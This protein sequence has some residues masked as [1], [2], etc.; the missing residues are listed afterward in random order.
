MESSKRTTHITYLGVLLICCIINTFR[1][2]LSVSVFFI[3]DLLLLIYLIYKFKDV[4]QAVSPLFFIGAILFFGYLIFSPE[5]PQIEYR[6]NF[7]VPLKAF[8]YICILS[9]F[10][11]DIPSFSIYRLAKFVVIIYPFILIWNA[12]IFFLKNGGTFLE[13]IR[14]SRPYFIF[15]NNFEITFYI[16]CFVILYFIF[17]DKNIYYFI[18]MSFAIFLAGSR[19]G[20]LSYAVICIFYFFA[21]NRRQKIIALIFSILAGGFVGLS[22]NIAQ[23]NVNSIDRLQTLDGL[24]K[25]YNHSFIEILKVPFG[26]GI[27]E[28]IPKYICSDLPDFAEWFNGSVHNCD[29]M[30]MQGFYSRSLFEF[31]IYITALIP[32]MFFWLIRGE[33]GTKLALVIAAPITCVATSVGGFSNGLAFWGI[34]LSIYA[35]IQQSNSQNNNISI[36][37]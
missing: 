22:R 30:M 19:S 6:N 23:L 29:P 18:L 7:I 15:E 24:L 8:I 1:F 16:N 10:S 32:I 12:F 27:Y 20:L 21:A 35:Y 13:I 3:P 33:T 11:R 2:N 14:G 34:L 4:N 5:P 37:P 28:K 26:F 9:I 17:K 31:G 36:T 25:E